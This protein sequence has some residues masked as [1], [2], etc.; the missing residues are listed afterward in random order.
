VT[1]AD[2]PISVLLVCTANI[3]R[4]A[5]AERLARHHLGDDASVVVTS[6]GTHGWD[7]HPVED[8]M[9]AELDRRGVAAEGFSSRPLTM[10]M[11]DAA[12]LVL[13]MD[14]RH[15]QFILDDRP[16]AVWRVFT[17]GQFARVVADLPADL[18]GRDLLAGLRG[19]H[20][21]ATPDD[22]VPDPYR[23]GPDAAAEAASRIDDLIGQ[24][25]PRLRH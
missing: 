1:P 16:E 5:F 17:L 8:L 19:V 9:A 4:S 18:H 2:R 7:E 14:S 10:A 23:R 22:D 13:T 20:K 25:L 11:V 21:P 12:D 24:A 15:R 6:A 3:C